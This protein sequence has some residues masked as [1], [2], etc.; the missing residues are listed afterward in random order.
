MMDIQGSCVKGFVPASDM[1]VRFSDEAGEVGLRGWLG[2]GA[3]GK[4]ETGLRKSA[5]SR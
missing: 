4:R 3:R 2:S 5:A 1:A